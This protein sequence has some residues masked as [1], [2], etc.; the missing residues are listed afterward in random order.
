MTTANRRTAL[1]TL[2]T[3]LGVVA[4]AFSPAT[5]PAQALT[6][7]GLCLGTGTAQL[8][9]PLGYPVGTT[10]G[11]L[12]S[13]HS[14]AFAL[15]FNAPLGVCSTIPGLTLANISATGTVHGWC[16]LFAGKG[17]TNLGD[18]FGFTGVGSIVVVTGELS[19]IVTAVPN[20]A[21]GDSCVNHTADDFLLTGVLVRG[22]CDFT[23][24][25]QS[26]V[27]IFVPP[28]NHISIHV[29]FCA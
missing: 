10:P 27:S 2:A 3:A 26:I 7:H 19:G 17:T 29:S 25:S 9:S 12:S 13:T 22:S 28:H 5:T 8:A 16:G 18:D 21:L 20:A 1:F 6:P 15:H 14:T 24:G 23:S 4:M 11:T